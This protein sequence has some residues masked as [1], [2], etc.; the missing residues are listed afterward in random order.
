MSAKKTKKKKSLF[1]RI[2]KWTGITFL[3]LIIALILIPIFFKDQLKDMALNEANK[4][5]KADI[6]LGDFDLTF[7]STFPNMTLTFEDITVV[8]REEFE[9]VHLVDIKRFDAHVGFWSVIGGSDIE[10]SSIILTEPKFDV[11]VLDNGLAN[12]DIVKSEEELKEEYPEEELESEPF[13]LT[14]SHYEIINGY[15][16][17]D[18][19]PSSMYA[20]LVNLNHEGNGDLSAD[21]IDFETLTSMDELTYKMDGIAYFSKV[22]FNLVMNLLMEFKDGSD[23]FTLKENELRLNELQLSFDGFY[24]MLDGYDDMDIVLKADQTSFK[25]LLSLVPVFYHTG[26]E[27][28]IAKGSLGLN[29]FVKGR[30]DDRNLPAFDFGLNIANASINYP[31]APSSIDDIK[32]VAGSKFPGG[33]NLDRLTINVSQFHSSFVGNTIDADFLMRNPMTDPYLKS[34]IIANVDLSTLDQVMPMEEG[35]TYNGKLNSDVIIEGKMSDLDNEDY[36][37]FTAKGTLALSEFHYESTD[38]PDGVDINEMLFVFSPAALSLENLEGK[39]GLTDFKMKGGVEDYLGY[40]FRDEPIK[41]TFD[42]SSQVLDLDAFMPESSE[43]STTGTAETQEEK[44]QEAA[45]EAL[46]PLLIPANIDFVLNTFIGDLKYD[47]MDIKNVKGKVTLR[48]EEAILD[49]LSMNMLDG[50]IT[51]TGKYSSQNHSKPMVNFTYSLIGIDIKQLT[52]NFES[53]ATMAPIS[54]NAEGKI[55]STFNMVGEVTP[56][57]EPIYNTLT[58]GGSLSTKSIQIV[59]YEPIERL[60]KVV[61]LDQFKNSTFRNVNI[62]FKFIDGRVHVDPFNINAG[63]IKTEIQGSTSFL[64]EIDYKLKMDVPKSEIPKEVLAIAEKAV[65]QAK[66]IPGFKMKELPDVIP[67]NALITNTVTDPK[68]QTDFKEQLMSL[69]GDVKGAV[70]ELVDE[71]VQEVKDSVKAVVDEK[72]QDVKDDLKERKQ[73]IMD[74]AQKQAD[75]V[76]SE[77]KRLA[78]RTRKEGDENA[79][80]IIDEAGSNPIKKRAAEATAQRV[81]EKAEESA[82]KI[83]READERADNIMKKAREQADRLE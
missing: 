45:E 20:E 43:A 50:A 52:E 21:V 37:A 54:K 25:G 29:G 36:E 2:L 41:G 22:N 4:M 12:Y 8:G 71:K 82:Q 15:V 35:E 63:N 55:S 28:M 9:G 61:E 57:F 3:L 34:Q 42:Y 44:V 68:I 74:D 78:D 76:K 24:E 11:R 69:G 75:K 49:N 81:R 66:N 79:Q 7:F 64:Q 1:R 47:G 10:I 80:K 13:N 83:E 16:R 73:K 60:S 39:M 53:I 18:D 23:K 48:D 62:N 65:S 6:G 27:S 14:L 58:G 17:Y 5:L 67:V 40:V 33:D 26:Y 56:S 19:K 70:K 77:A 72:V 30:M 46:E 31:D 59:D 51:L 32:V 38:L